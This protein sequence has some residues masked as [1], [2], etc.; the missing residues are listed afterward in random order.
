MLVEMFFGRIDARTASNEATGEMLERFFPGPYELIRPG[1]DIA[2]SRRSSRPPRGRIRIVHCA[3]EE[4]GRAAALPARAA[5]AARRARLGSRDLVRR[6]DRSARAG[7]P[8]D[9]RARC[10][11][12]RP[13]DGEPA[14]AFIAG[15]DIVCLASGG[16]RTAPGLAREALAAGAVP[17]VSDLELYR[18]LVGDGERGLLFPVGDALTLAR[19]ARAAR[20]ATTGC[21]RACAAAGRG[22]AEGRPG[23]RSPTRSRRSTGGS[24]PRRHDPPATRRVAQ[25]PG[26]PALI[27][28]DLHMHTDHSPDCA[29][30]VRALLG[31][32]EG[33]GPRR[34]RDHRP[35]RDLGRVRGPRDRRARSAGSR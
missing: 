5:E 14:Q 12:V 22:G 6:A 17:V 1:A 21:E 34:H 31:D 10:A 18:E 20:R 15:A 23:P 19:A 35:Q 28:C 11:V 2:P 27:H 30:P 33:A 16:V 29:T 8:P 26:G 7:E 3:E 4:R 24:P 9:A 13:R 25:A 32:G